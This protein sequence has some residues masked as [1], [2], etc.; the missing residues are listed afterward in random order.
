MMVTMEA[1]GLRVTAG[2]AVVTEIGM[3]SAASRIRSSIT[4]IVRHSICAWFA[5]VNVI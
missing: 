2:S 5:G 1:E 4:G 3:V